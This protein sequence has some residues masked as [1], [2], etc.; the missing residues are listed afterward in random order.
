MV[1]DYNSGDELFHIFMENLLHTRKRVHSG[2]MRVVKQPAI[3]VCVC[4]CVNLK[5][6]KFVKEE[7]NPFRRRKRKTPLCV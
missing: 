5:T 3:T 4:V 2:V 7:K 1:D 6:W